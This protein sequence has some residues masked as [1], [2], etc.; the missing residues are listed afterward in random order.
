MKH[1]RLNLVL[2]TVTLDILTIVNPLLRDGD[3]LVVLTVNFV[4]QTMDEYLAVSNTIIDTLM[5]KYNKEIILKL[6][7][8]YIFFLN[9]SCKRYYIPKIFYF[10]FTRIG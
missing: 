3:N 10:Y 7:I 1:V 4:P 8:H 9:I 6:N 2:L 5:R